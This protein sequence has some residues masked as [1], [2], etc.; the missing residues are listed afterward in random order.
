MKHKCSFKYILECEEKNSKKVQVK[1]KFHAS[2][3]EYQL[4]RFVLMFY[5][6]LLNCYYD[7]V[8]SRFRGLLLSPFQSP[9]SFSHETQ[10]RA[11]IKLCGVSVPLQTM[12][13]FY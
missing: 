8:K 13:F 11:P 4:G 1:F 9:T 7:K 10:F 2:S 5:S 3:G 12:K 6:A